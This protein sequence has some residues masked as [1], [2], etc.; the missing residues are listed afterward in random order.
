M[1]GLGAVTAFTTNV[2][3][4]AAGKLPCDVRV[5]AGADFAP[6]KRNRTGLDLIEDG[7]AVVAILA[8]SAR[9][10]E[11]PQDQKENESEQ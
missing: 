2:V 6:G 8:E 10:G 1:G 5:A 7:S 3:M 11:M 9:D 4:T